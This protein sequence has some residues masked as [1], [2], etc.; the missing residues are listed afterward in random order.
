[1]TLTAP[2][3]PATP[4]RRLAAEACAPLLGDAIPVDTLTALPIAV[5]KL[6]LQAAVDVEAEAFPEAVLRPL[7]AGGGASLCTEISLRKTSVSDRGLGFIGTACGRH[8]LRLDLSHC[9]RLR[10]AGVIALA[11]RCPQLQQLNLS[12]CRL[13]D[14]AFE[15][16][17]QSCHD[18]RE[19]DCSWNGSGV[20]EP[21]ARALAA[22]CVR[23]E[24]LAICGCRLGDEA[25]LALACACPMLSRL[26]TRG[27]AL[28]TEAG[29]VAALSPS[30]AST[31]S[32]CRSCLASPSP[33][34]TSSSTA[35]PPPPPLPPSG[36][37]TSPCARAWATT[38]SRASRRGCRACAPSRALACRASS[39]P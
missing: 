10:D 39:R 30:R 37:W 8:L 31:P 15:C 5:R 20:G 17:A 13:T 29:V 24:R 34:C 11:R 38:R 2:A 27:C 25:L 6:L 1:M 19:L 33:A 4:L 21:T 28:L 9:S 35:R 32:S 12:H 36:R 16:V 18:L 23:L 14:A 26:A 22:H 7:L 3:T